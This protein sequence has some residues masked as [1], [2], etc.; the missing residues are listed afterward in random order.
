MFY[1]TD[2]PGL[3]S[4]MVRAIGLW[5]HHPAEFRQLIMQGMQCDYSWSK[6]GQDYL[7]VYNYIRQI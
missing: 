5:Q 3:D 2:E 6:P 1:Q 4:A 7:N